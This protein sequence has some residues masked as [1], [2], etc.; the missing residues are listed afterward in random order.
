MTRE[1]NKKNPQAAT[2]SITDLTNRGVKKFGLRPELIQVALQTGGK[3]QYTLKEA[4][5]LIL[6]FQKRKV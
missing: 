4:Q 2:Y 1:E 6:A 3:E 5:K